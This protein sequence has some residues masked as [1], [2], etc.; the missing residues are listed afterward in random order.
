MSKATRA[1]GFSASSLLLA[2]YVGAVDCSE[3]RFRS[4][5]GRASSITIVGWDDQYASHA[6]CAYQQTKDPNL[7]APLGCAWPDPGAVQFSCG[8]AFY[9]FSISTTL[10]ANDQYWFRDN[11]PEYTRVVLSRS[12]GGGALYTA[13]ADEE[14]GPADS[15][16][17]GRARIKSNSAL[18]PLTYY[19]GSVPDDLDCGSS[20][21]SFAGCPYSCD[22]PEGCDANY[23]KR[24][25]EFYL[26]SYRSNSEGQDTSQTLFDAYGAN[27]SSGT[28]AGP[29][30][31]LDESGVCV[32]GSSSGLK[33]DLESQC[34]GGYC[35]NY[36]VTMRRNTYTGDAVNVRRGENRRNALV[37]SWVKM[38]Y[39]DGNNQEI[40][41][42]NRFYS[43]DNYFVFMVRE[44]G[45]DL[46]WIHRFSGGAFSIVTSSATSL[47][48][49]T[50]NRLGFE[51][52]DNGSYASSG[53][54]V[55]SG[56]CKMRG[57]V[58]GA[59]VLTTDTA[60]C[61]FAPYGN[62]GVYS[63]YNSSAQFWDLD[64]FP[65]NAG[66]CLK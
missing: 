48:L 12:S 66:R 16:T 36:W 8:V 27:G 43:A 14:K 42:A 31:Y 29:W 58:N 17:C 60:T 65:C 6:V 24:P 46:A 56:S 13:T 45:G 28:P 33:C 1:L 55:P 50:W 37:E 3:G 5:S 44:Y 54:F 25:N 47:N 38:K 19:N 49:L 52:R 40:G 4:V 11:G 34:P 9:P 59:T 57:Y 22:I 10:L 30:G 7:T 41:I 62:Y 35:D 2:G 64:A 18:A 32:G 51:V 26:T 63:Y 39:A 21:R 15:S 20:P 23:G 61:S 53:A